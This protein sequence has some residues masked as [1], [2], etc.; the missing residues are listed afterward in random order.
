M[1]STCVQS[2]TFAA[3]S[4][5][6][7]FLASAVVARATV[8]NTTNPAEIA[9]FKSGA[10]VQTFDSIAG[11]TPVAIT[12]YNPLDITLNTGAHFTKD[13]TQTPFYNSG[14]ANPLDPVSTP[15]VPV[16]IVTPTGGIAG[17][18]LSGNNV[19]G[20]LG[21]VVPPFT[22]FEGGAFIEV[23]FPTLVSKVGLFVAHGSIQMF[24]KDSAGNNLVTGDV[25]TSGSAGQ[26]IGIDRGT[27]DIG[28]L[29][30]GFGAFTI[31][32]LTFGGAGAG[33]GNAVPDTGSAF[34]LALA[35][36]FIALAC[37]RMRKA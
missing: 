35:G 37:W 16:G 27:A 33:G 23:I 28:G 36:A 25:S 29:T 32:D 6:L 14:G 15:G 20:P 7:A 24:L 10:T 1:R 18:K 4:A 11:V 5:A 13:A 26:F 3:F 19:A 8:I 9:A 17:D 22:L 12:D 31:D 2:A 21:V 34:N 30:L